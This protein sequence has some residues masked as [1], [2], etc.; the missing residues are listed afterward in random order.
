MRWY[1]NIVL[2]E[3]TT[4]LSLGSFFNHYNTLERFSNFYPKNIPTWIKGA[5]KKQRFVM[6]EVIIDFQRVSVS[7]H[8]CSQ[9]MPDD[10]QYIRRVAPDH[11]DSL[12]AM[13]LP[14]GFSKKN[15][16]EVVRQVKRSAAGDAEV[17]SSKRVRTEAG[18]QRAWTLWCFRLLNRVLSLG[19]RMVSQFRPSSFTVKHIISTTQVALSKIV[20][21]ATGEEGTIVFEHKNVTVKGDLSDSSFKSGSMKR[22]FDVSTA[23]HS[24]LHLLINPIADHRR[25]GVCCEEVLVVWRR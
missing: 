6:L 3:G 13:E 25:G 7:S 2:E 22:S 12:D 1:D 8:L 21:R 18:T 19:S 15:M 10:S 17:S 4:G 23:T 14:G 24:W 20:C 9:K 16:A 5:A 11:E